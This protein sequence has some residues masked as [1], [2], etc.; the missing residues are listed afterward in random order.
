M[1][2]EARHLVLDLTAKSRNWGLT[3]G[4]EQ[5]VRAEAPPG[6]VVDVV[7]APTSSDG[8]GPPRG[9]EEALRLMPDAEVY[10]GFG[11]THDLLG[12]ARRLRWVHSAAAGVGSVL[13]TGI[14][15]TDILL[16]NS[17][18]VHGPPIG[19]FVVAGVLHFM[20]GFDVAIDQQRR[21]EWNKAFFVAEESPLREVS[22]A[23]VL[24]VGTG[25]LGREAAWR[26][27]ALGATCVGIR[28]RPELGAPEGFSSVAGME[29]FD[30]E[31]RKA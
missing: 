28:R 12:A 22:G 14:A 9:S 20:R 27:A 16:T 4:A 11:I 21:A 13:E 8:D 25:G 31:L 2:T 17:A 29:A 5:R 15:D 30:S 19:E 6:W 23:R 26:F 10:F 3:P 1:S 7:R 24:I 18:G